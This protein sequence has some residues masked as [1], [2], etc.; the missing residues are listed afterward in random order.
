MKKL[1][2]LLVI[3]MFVSGLS[4]AQERG[5]G[6]RPSRTSEGTR[7][8]NGQERQQMTPEQMLQRQTQRLVD[9]LK[10]NKDQEKKVSA[11]N[12]KYMD[13]QSFDWSKMRDASDDERTKMREEMRKIQ[14]EREKE[15]LGVLTAE[16][17]KTFKENQKKREENRRNGQGGFGG[18]MGGR[19]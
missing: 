9:E 8:A 1:A 12:K 14:T 13:K 5:S 15:I 3:I 2:T 18:G 19:Q 17:A 16:Q 10:L 4:Y 11:I 6:Q 7:P